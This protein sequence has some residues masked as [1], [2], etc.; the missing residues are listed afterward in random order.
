MASENP[1]Y[2]EYKGQVGWWWFDETEDLYGP[3]ETED[4]A[5]TDL[6]KYIKEML[7]HIPVI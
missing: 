5:K 6:Q 7:G 2:G 3:Y 1:Y 4:K